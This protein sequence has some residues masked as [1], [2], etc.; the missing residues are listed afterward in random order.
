MYERHF[1]ISSLPFR[2]TP[3][4]DFY[5][6][7]GQHQAALTALRDAY[8]REGA[9]VVLSGEIGS[10]KT[11]V[12]RRALEEARDEGI[13]TAQLTNTQLGSDDLKR[14]AAAAFGIGALQGS[15]S[16]AS[17]AWRAWVEGLGGRRALLVIDEAQ[18]LDVEALRWLLELADMAQAARTALRICLAGQSE[19]RQRLMDPGLVDL[20]RRTQRSCHLQPLNAQETRCYIEHRLAKVGWHGQP[21]IDSAAFEVI[22]RLAGGI[23]RRVNM[24]CN[25]LLM[26]LFLA[27]GSCV[28]VRVV[29]SMAHTLH[30]E[31]DDPTFADLPLVPLRESGPEVPEGDAIWLLTAG[32]S[33]EVR[34]VPLLRAMQAHGALPAALV[35]SASDGSF[36]QLN[37]ALH[38][39]A[40]IAP[41][42]VVLGAVEELGMQALQERFDALLSRRPPRA[43]V[44][45]DGS[46]CALRCAEI[47]HER[48]VPIVHIGASAQGVDEPADNL[49]TRSAIARLAALRFDGG[50]SATQAWTRDHRVVAAGNLLVDA[51]H[52]S[53]RMSVQGLPCAVEQPVFDRYRGDL[54]GY[55]VIVLK[56]AARGAAGPCHEET[57]AVLR[58]V[59]RDVP[60]V[61]PMRR[62]ALQSM[63]G[64]RV[65]RMFAG[66]RI[67]CI[68]ELSHAAFLRLL[69]DATCVLTDCLDV[70][71]EAVALGIGC[72]S[73][74]ARHA[75]S[76]DAGGWLPVVEVGRSVTR[77]TRAVWQMTFGGGAQVAPLAL[78]DGRTAARIASRLGG[79][80]TE[81][82]DVVTA[83]HA[84]A[85]P[86]G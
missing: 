18:N 47:A 50:T 31:T 48:G 76:V 83:L 57:A 1:G 40:G 80:L 23:P 70:Q 5:F 13:L 2:L 43:L 61:W 10:G 63:Q 69:R 26:Q 24:L 4:P 65:A 36:W 41:R 85:R 84:D 12:L 72:L 15:A 55:G 39:F 56:Q 64:T 46:A 42:L 60:L 33:D 77:A 79:W 45:F 32:R 73:L 82:G 3:D 17:D 38:A 35:A 58:A 30:V 81:R 28:D 66:D 16:E 67:A 37:R 7:T 74:G 21:S 68:E 44:V 62:A 53:L 86:P 11:T 34:A 9:F 54:R 27:G 78:W 19:L 29:Q 75:A 52:L 59:S 14:A 71:E 20:A 6:E 51:V 49:N 22:H 8:A 25:R